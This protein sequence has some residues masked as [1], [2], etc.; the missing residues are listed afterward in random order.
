MQT[1]DSAEPPREV[2]LKSLERCV[3]DREFIPAFYA[4]FIATSDEVREKFKNTDF[5]QQT[6]MLVRS[7]RLAAGATAGNPESLRELRERATTHDRNHLDIAPHLYSLWLA[8]LMETAC[9]HDV[10]W[11]AAIEEAWEI[12]LGHVIDHMIAHY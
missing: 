3:A 11:N 6:R 10:L 4:R 9:K 12:I 1:G 8:A 5:E 7:L 2:F